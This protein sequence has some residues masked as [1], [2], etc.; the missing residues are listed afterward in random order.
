MIISQILGCYGLSS[1][2]TMCNK[3]L[4]RILDAR[5]CLLEAVA[6]HD[7]DYDNNSSR[8]NIVVIKLTNVLQKHFL[9][10]LIFPTS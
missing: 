2:H 4:K 1:K 9:P 3:A 6:F 7:V 8:F 10:K 5:L